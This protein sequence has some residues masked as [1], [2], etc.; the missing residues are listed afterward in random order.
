MNQ[1]VERRVAEG[2]EAVRKD[3]VRNRAGRFAGYVEAVWTEYGYAKINLSLDVLRKRPDGYHDLRMVM[4]TIDL[5]D[6]ITL[7]AE[8][9]PGIRLSVSIPGLET[10]ERNLAYRAAKVL[11]AYKGLENVVIILTDIENYESEKLMYVGLSRACSG[12]FV[13]ESDAAKREYDSLL[14]RRL[15]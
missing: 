5:A 6:R 12:L 11:L 2:E 15:M 1:E 7:E 8:E 10:D 4:Q 14:I 3:T 9:K 13:L